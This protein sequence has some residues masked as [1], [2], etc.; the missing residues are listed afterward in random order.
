MSVVVTADTA[1][2]EVKQQGKDGVRLANA[3][4]AVQSA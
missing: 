3:R 4:P 2:Y 1:M